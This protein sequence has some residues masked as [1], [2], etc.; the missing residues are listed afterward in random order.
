MTNDNR[1]TKGQPT[2]GQFAA[3]TYTEADV[4]LLSSAM[5]EA[6]EAAWQLQQK[7]LLLRAQYV[8][9]SVLVAYPNAATVKLV[10]SDQED[11]TWSDDY[12]L[13]ADGN[14]IADSDD[15]D[16]TSDFWEMPSRVPSVNEVQPDGSSA[17]VDDPKFAWL[18]ITHNRRSGSTAIFDVR[19][20]A[21]I[22]DNN[23]EEDSE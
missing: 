3:K 10:E 18:K 20:A 16:L 2:G 6:G 19:A 11:C 13:D 23:D 5:D 8:A 4:E 12:I 14:H 9:T 1:V 15:L 17:R 21:A 7:S 22:G